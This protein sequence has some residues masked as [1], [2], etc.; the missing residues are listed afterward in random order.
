MTDAMV[1]HFLCTNMIQS[2]G[3]RLIALL[4]AVLLATSKKMES[5]VSTVYPLA[6]LLT[7]VSLGPYVSSPILL[8]S[9]DTIS[10]VDLR[11]DLPGEFNFI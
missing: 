3:K 1:Y 7:W 8:Q 5:R 2:H 11:Q 4:Q 6:S 10:N 9:S